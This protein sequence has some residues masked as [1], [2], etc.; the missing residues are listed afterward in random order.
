MAFSMTNESHSLN[1]FQS[2]SVSYAL[3]TFER[4]ALNVLASVAQ[5]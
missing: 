1:L 2:L 4:H 3:H 5:P